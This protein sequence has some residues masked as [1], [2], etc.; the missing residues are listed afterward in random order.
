MR[1]A[2]PDGPPKEDGSSSPFVDSVEAW[3]GRTYIN[4]VG[5]QANGKGIIESGVLKEL[6]SVVEDKVDA[7][8]LLQTLK[9]ATSDETF[10]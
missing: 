9:K 1:Y 3:K 2:H 7:G 6:G 4:T 8:K 5:N 10:Q